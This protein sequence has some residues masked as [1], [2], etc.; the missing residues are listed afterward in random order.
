MA[1]DSVKLHVRP[2]A[3]YSS[4]LWSR[5]DARFMIR[6]PFLLGAA[7]FCPETKWN[8]IARLVD[9]MSNFRRSSDYSPELASVTEKLNTNSNQLQQ[10]IATSRVNQI[11]NLIINFHSLMRN[12]WR[13]KFEISGRQYLHQALSEGKGV[14]LWVAHFAFASLFTKMAL[15]QAGY[16]ISHLSRP[17]HGVSKS[18]F[19]I[20]YL[21]WFRCK[22]ENRNLNLRI[23]YVRDQPQLARDAAL[24]ALG[25]NELLSITVGAWEGRHLATGELLGS[26]Y[27]VSTGAPKL[28]FLTGAKLLS[29]FTT[30]NGETGNYEVAV[31]APLA[32]RYHSSQEEF[33]RAS[34]HELM[35]RHEVAIRKAPEQWRGWGK[36]LD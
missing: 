34:T 22:A 16:R 3:V 6:A 29:V 1:Q 7:I 10:I 4:G 31:S 26:H 12:E 25:R 28:A 23:I 35:T 19:R 20:K 21:N 27:T 13:P 18:R 8:E 30:R 5:D 11:E 15:F 2:K 32:E 24:A 33:I 36:V 17:E 14:V 9:S